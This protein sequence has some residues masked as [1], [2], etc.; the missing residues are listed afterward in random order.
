MADYSVFTKPWRDLSV[1]DLIR[2]VHDLGYNAIEFPLR[3]GFQVTPDQARE[4]L[5]QFARQLKDA[6]IRLD[7]VAS[8]PEE[9][10][11]DA[12]ANA[13]VP[14]IRVM[15][16]P[17]QGD[18]AGQEAE[19]LRT[20][21]SWLPLC[22]KYGVKVGVQMH[23][24]RGA[25]TSADLMRVV[26]RFDARYVGAIWDAAHSGLAGEDPEQA[27]DVCW[28]HLCLV[29]FKNARYQMLGRDADGAMVFKAYF[30]PGSDGQCSWPRAVAHLKAKGYQGTWCMPAEYTGLSKEDEILYTKRDLA[31]L[32]TLVEEPRP[33]C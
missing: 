26:G 22:E 24:G 20:V 2:T 5:P 17:P 33:C 15:F 16:N 8:T 25:M 10:I 27:I 13:G 11:F 6:G 31:W 7:D 1:P 32:K 23:H 30:C 28:S 12:C 9:H 18:Y 19:Y 21:E 4:K 29:N 14:M 3:D